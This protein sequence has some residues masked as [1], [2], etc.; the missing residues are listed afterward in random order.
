[1]PLEWTYELK[2]GIKWIDDQHLKLI[3]RFDKAFKVIEESHSSE[4][5]NLLLEFMI[6]FSNS[7]F[8]TEEKYMMGYKYP[9]LK[10]HKEEHIILYT[11]I[12]TLKKAIAKHKNSEKLSRAVAIQLSN[13]YE[14]H[15]E[16]WD[17]ELAAFLRSK[18][19]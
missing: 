13:W 17:Y 1:M 12:N 7:H 16:E 6:S 9:K 2:T 4:E 5:A 10:A 18:Q 3:E 19:K 14:E 11:N 15:I 8:Q